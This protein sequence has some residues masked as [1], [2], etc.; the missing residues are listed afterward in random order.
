M[1]LSKVL[2]GFYRATSSFRTAI[3]WFG[4]RDRSGADANVLPRSRPGTDA[5]RSRPED[6]GA[7]GGCDVTRGNAGG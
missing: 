3:W 5:P 4:R 2:A 7:D 1:Q 6:E